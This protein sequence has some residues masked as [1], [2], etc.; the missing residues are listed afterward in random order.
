M[1]NIYLYEKCLNCGYVASTHSV[2]ELS[3]TVKELL[4]VECPRC[5]Q[6]LYLGVVMDFKPENHE[7]Y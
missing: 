3:M 7:T 6:L 1:L 5:A 2:N 4:V